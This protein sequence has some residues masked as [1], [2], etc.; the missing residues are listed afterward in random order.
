MI[1]LKK[2]FSLARPSGGPFAEAENVA[3]R[4][5]DVEIETRPRLLFKRL[6]NACLAFLQFVEQATDTLDGDERVQ[7]FV[8]LAMFTR[9]GQLRRALEM[10]RESVATDARVEILVLEV[11]L[12]AKLVTVVGNG[13]IKIVD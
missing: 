8:L 9:G 10:D 4:I 1:K 2:C 11:E 5:F 13:S 6:D 12:E 7:M 3:V